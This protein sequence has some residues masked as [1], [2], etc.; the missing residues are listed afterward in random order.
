MGY[1]RTMPFHRVSILGVGLLGGS[2]GLAARS[3]LTSCKIA[4]YGHRR[5]SLDKALEIGAIDESYDTA[6]AAVR[7]AGSTG[8]RWHDL[9]DTASG[10][11]PPAGIDV[12]VLQ[13]LLGHKTLAMTM[14]YTHLAPE[15]LRA[16]VKLVALGGTGRGR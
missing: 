5:G 13:Q 14:R 4:G 1:Y 10:R 9:P 12:R 7:G 11:A 2:I 16:A 15:G 6:E 8:C 3:R